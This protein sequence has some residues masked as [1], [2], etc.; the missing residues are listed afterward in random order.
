M[1]GC[2]AVGCNNRS[3]KG[4]TMKCFPRN[5]KLRK[6]W[7]ERVGRAD[8]EPSNNS[9][10]CHMHF[11]PEQW[12]V[13]NDGKVKL[14][15]D[16]LPSIFTITSTRKSP[17]KRRKWDNAIMYDGEQ[18]G[19]TVNYLEHKLE[20]PAD[21]FAQGMSNGTN[22][23][24]VSNP[25]TVE[26]AS[27][28]IIKD[29]KY[30]SDDDYQ[31]LSENILQQVDED[32]VIIVSEKNTR[33]I[34]K[35][36]HDNSF[37]IVADENDKEI[38]QLIMNDNTF[39]EKNSGTAK[40]EVIGDSEEDQSTFDHNYDEIEEKLKQICDGDGSPNDIKSA[41]MI[42][43][44][45]EKNVNK[46]SIIT[47]NG[48]IK[49]NIGQ[50]SGNIEN[51]FGDSENE[52]T[53]ETRSY[54][55]QNHKN[56]VVNPEVPK[57]PNNKKTTM[58]QDENMSLNNI[59]QVFAEDLENFGRD[60]V[61]VIP[62]MRAAMKRKRRTREEIMKSIEKT[63][64]SISE[65]DLKPY[66]Q[67]VVMPEK[68][69]KRNDKKR[70]L[71]KLLSNSRD[72]DSLA[73]N[74][75][76]F[77]IK[78]TGVSDYVTDIIKG[79]ETKSNVTYDSGEKLNIPFCDDEGN[80]FITSVIAVQEG[81]LDGFK[82]DENSEDIENT[83]SNEQ[84]EYIAS[85]ALAPPRSNRAERVLRFNENL[86]HVQEHERAKDTNIKYVSWSNIRKCD[87]SDPCIAADTQNQI[88]KSGSPFKPNYANGSSHFYKELQRKVGVQQEVINRLSNQ[89]IMYKD[90][91]NKLNRV[92]LELQL[93]NKEID[94]LSRKT[95]KKSASVQDKHGNRKD[96]EAKQKQIHDLS[97]RIDQLDEMNK[98]LMKTVTLES[99]NKRKLEAQ[100]KQKD[101]R[102]KELNWKLDKAAKFLERAEKNTNTYKKKMTRMQTM[103]RRQKLLDERNGQFKEMLIDNAKHDFS[104]ASLLTAMDIKNL[105][106]EKGYEKLLSYDFPL[107][108]LR[109]LRK[110]F[111]KEGM[112]E[113]DWNEE[114]LETPL[115][116]SDRADGNH[117]KETVDPESSEIIETITP[118]LNVNESNGMEQ[119]DILETVTGTVQDI[120]DENNDADDL[121]SSELSEHFIMQ[122][123]ANL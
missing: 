15:K 66:N 65:V 53:N 17:R 107:P 103:L 31:M 48:P 92:N 73:S 86:Q 77:T 75:T 100:I 5:P 26:I 42:E 16:A 9:F 54:L 117:Q 55:A 114:K 4:Y 56:S 14:K 74:K 101:D 80:S 76:K 6:I 39:A 97:T 93:K 43:K 58:L 21:V 49:K 89:L 52:S 28:I 81:D 2:A 82:D 83:T 99:Q 96:L 45:I 85:E 59:R 30:S 118:E 71:H 91:E 20:Y 8:W 109:T 79:L 51:I 102:I 108:S 57:D 27:E 12:I 78:V 62:N 84:K 67:T 61:H 38:G 37:I 68:S 1:P 24:E 111:L 69:H 63:I 112:T 87:S 41:Y 46:K 47:K 34:R 36:I 60:E 70:A 115:S 121:N 33:E 25:Q 110:R 120:F 64:G 123:N 122:L 88:K 94:E 119:V 32:N 35:L 44:K 106:G 113:D 98:K 11:T 95:N 50:S 105:C 22:E 13:T 104:E 19:Y 7:T 3:E 18:A 29:E 90:L 40:V 116:E 23:S 72:T 10:L